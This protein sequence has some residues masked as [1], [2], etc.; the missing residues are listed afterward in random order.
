[1]NTLM[2][3]TFLPLCWFMFSWWKFTITSGTKSLVSYRFLSTL[4]ELC[5]KV[6]SRC[7]VNAVWNL[8]R[9]LWNFIVLVMCVRALAAVVELWN[10]DSEDSSSYLDFIIFRNCIARLFAVGTTVG[11]LLLFFLDFLLFAIC[12][13]SAFS[14]SFRFCSAVIVWPCLMLICKLIRYFC[15]G[16]T[17]C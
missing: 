14:W 9:C 1:M 15:M 6:E 5:I 11:S 10:C 7:C 17:V 3:R 4:W 2:E 12:L 16:S 13:A 8:V